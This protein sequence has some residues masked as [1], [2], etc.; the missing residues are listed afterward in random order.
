MDASLPTLMPLGDSAL[1]IRFAT[2][3]DDGANRAAVAVARHLGLAPPH[4]VTEIV[5]SLVSVLVR[6]DPRSVGYDELTGALRLAISSHVD[7]AQD[8]TRHAI[9]VRFGGEAGPD[10]AEVARQ[11]EL[12]EDAFIAR[13]NANALRVL[14]T[15][16]A[17]GFVYCGLHP[18]GL[19][20]SRRQEVRSRVPAGSVLF[21]A[22]QTAITAT[23]VPTG[24]YVIGRTA[25]RNFDPAAT[26]PTTLRPGD[27]VRFES[28][29]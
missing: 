19:H 20:L 7:T 27:G 24:W 28:N 15:G 18:D 14:A 4:G 9:P 12:S 25:F 26:P 21:A 8:G 5:P 13:H 11:L 29:I 22:G 17:P 23:P 3:L 6:Y 16:F 10:L 2:R 1:L